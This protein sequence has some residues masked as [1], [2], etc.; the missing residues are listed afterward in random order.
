MVL[1]GASEQGPEV[2]ETA[3]HFGLIRGGPL[4]RLLGRQLLRQPLS[5]NTAR[6]LYLE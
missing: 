4:G 2:S 1:A 5:E 6:F 3:Y